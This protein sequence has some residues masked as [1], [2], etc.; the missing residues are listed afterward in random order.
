MASAGD[1]SDVAT[2]KAGGVE[3]SIVVVGGADVHFRSMMYAIDHDPSAPS[4][5]PIEVS[6]TYA[7]NKIKPA[8]DHTSLSGSGL[9]GRISRAQRL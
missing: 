1:N 6:L 8:Q 9:A 3:V 7:S 4:P 5:R 2:P